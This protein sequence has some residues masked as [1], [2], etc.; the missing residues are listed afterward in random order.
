[1][2]SRPQV[3]APH[4]V[5]VVLN[6]HDTART[7]TCAR[8]LLEEEA[9]GSVVLVDNETSGELRKLRGE[10]VE[11]VE[12]RENLGFARG[13]N[14]G[15]RLALSAGA[16]AVL[17]INSDVTFAAGE[18]ARLVDGWLECGDSTGVVAPLI[19][20]E[21][22]SVQSRGGRFRALT[23]ATHDLAASRDLDFITWACVL[24]PRA[25]FESVGLLDERFFMY[26]EDVDFGLRVKDSGRRLRIM[27][28]VEVAHAKSVSHGR[29]GAKID[30]YSARGL[31]LLSL[32][33]GGAAKWLGMPI[34]LTARLAVRWRRRDRLVAVVRGAADGFRVYR[35]CEEE[36][37]A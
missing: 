22:G 26:W 10:R 11:I 34:R 20:N 2:S 5:A 27:T 35:A 33:R 13:V 17:A 30:Q 24:V 1:V 23:G 32:K 37:P 16:D 12:H 9:I 4:V 25:T 19:L 6:W 36:G 29:A 18:L 31:V 21:D 15:I 8:T 28:H 3:V 7:E 14:S